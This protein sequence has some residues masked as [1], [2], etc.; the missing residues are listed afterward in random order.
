MN[1]LRFASQRLSNSLAITS[2]RC[3]STE[4]KSAAIGLRTALEEYRQTNYSYEVPTRFKKDIVA[5]ACRT[6]NTG[7]RLEGMQM[8]LSNLGLKDRVS[9]VDLQLLF[10]Q[11]GDATGVINAD[12]MFRIL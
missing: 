12:R 3:L 7:V 8:V 2:T 1:A 10:D 5:A 9:Q 4:V 11:E 6:G